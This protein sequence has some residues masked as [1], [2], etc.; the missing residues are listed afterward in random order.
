MTQPH[1]DQAGAPR[2]IE[3]MWV[4]PGQDRNGI[5]LGL[6]GSVAICCGRTGLKVKLRAA[7]LRELA[8]RLL[9]VAEGLNEDRRWAES[10]PRSTRLVS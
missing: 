4:D 1:D 2:P 6:D 9:M 8:A 7:E 10:V 3:L 5:N